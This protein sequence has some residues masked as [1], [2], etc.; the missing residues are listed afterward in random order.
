MNAP[1]EVVQAD[2]AAVSGDAVKQRHKLRVRQRHVEA[3]E[4]L[5]QLI[6]INH[7]GPCEVHR[8]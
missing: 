4:Q 3:V 8:W 1:F 7:S 6:H 2:A 5:A